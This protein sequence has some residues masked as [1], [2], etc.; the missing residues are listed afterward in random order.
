[1]Q[2]SF[3]SRNNHLYKDI[4]AYTAEQLQ[5]IIKQK[6]EKTGNYEPN[7]DSA[8]LKKLDESSKSV[9]YEN[10][11]IKPVSD[12]FP[13]NIIADHQLD[14][15]KNNSINIYENDLGHSCA[16]ITSAEW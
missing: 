14:K 7:P 2:V 8:L 15:I 3:T 4:P 5:E 6:L 13:Q 10:F 12:E 11:S 1:M 9:L 16:I